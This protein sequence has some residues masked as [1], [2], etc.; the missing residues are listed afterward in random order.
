MSA[1][2][3]PPKAL[4]WAPQRQV[5][6]LTREEFLWVSWKEELVIDENLKDKLSSRMNVEGQKINPDVAFERNW[7]QIWNYNIGQSPYRNLAITIN[8]METWYSYISTEWTRIKFYQ[9]N[10]MFISKNK[11]HVNPHSKWREIELDPSNELRILWC[12]INEAGDVVYVRGKMDWC[13]VIKVPKD[14][15]AKSSSPV[16]MS[17]WDIITKIRGIYWRINNNIPI[18]FFITEDWKVIVV[19]KQELDEWFSIFINWEKVEW[20]W[21]IHKIKDWKR[22]WDDTLYIHY[23]AINWV[24]LYAKIF[25]WE[26]VKRMWEVH[27][28]VT[29]AR[30]GTVRALESNSRLKGE[31]NELKW[32]LWA[33]EWEIETLK[34][35]IREW[36]RKLWEGEREITQLGNEIENLKRKLK[37]KDDEIHW[38]K[39]EK[40]LLKQEVEKLGNRINWVVKMLEWFVIKTWWA[41]I[42]WTKDDENWLGTFIQNAVAK[43]KW[44]K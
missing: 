24:D 15:Y 2:W 37:W 23:T 29:M 22:V 25:L 5:T 18:S 38:L 34:W 32:K 10:V 9:S 17:G 13:E 42:R 41:L 12:D 20:A 4:D 27:L 11:I 35:K 16:Y 1:L 43:L 30:A 7:L 28:A 8:G 40:E 21:N 26:A 3:S 6:V 19:W 31:N 33:I 14:N 39:R 44:L 36:E